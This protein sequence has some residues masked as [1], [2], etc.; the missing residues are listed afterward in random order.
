[1][2]DP[3]HYKSS[4]DN[5]TFDL[6]ELLS[7]RCCKCGSSLLDRV[8]CCSEM[9]GMWR[10]VF[11]LHNRTVHRCVNNSFENPPRCASLSCFYCCCMWPSRDLTVQRAVHFC[12]M[13]AT[14]LSCVAWP[15]Q[16]VSSHV[17]SHWISI[18]F[19]R[20]GLQR[21]STEA[22]AEKRSFILSTSIKFREYI[23][24]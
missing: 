20:V 2:C 4:E 15:L 7:W 17:P 18:V 21:A 11:L 22:V 23:T 19:V 5:G 6:A 12:I 16:V 1:M 3:L 13:H 10:L 8:H 9:F 24:C 14:S